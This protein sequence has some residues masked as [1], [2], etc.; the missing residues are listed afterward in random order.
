MVELRRHFRA[1]VPALALERD[2]RQPRREHRE[3]AGEQRVAQQIQPEEQ[4]RRPELGSPNDRTGQRGDRRHDQ[5]IPLEPE[6][7]Q[8]DRREQPE[9]GAVLLRGHA[10]QA[11]ERE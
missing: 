2:L 10:E 11:E 1:R 4:Q 9:R 8:A 3:P 7:H 5:Q 6:R